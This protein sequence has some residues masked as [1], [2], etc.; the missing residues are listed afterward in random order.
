[1]REVLFIF[2]LVIA[3]VAITYITTLLALAVSGCLMFLKYIPEWTWTLVL[4]VLTVATVRGL[5]YSPE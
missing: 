4:L 1:M 3:I 2:I 5:R